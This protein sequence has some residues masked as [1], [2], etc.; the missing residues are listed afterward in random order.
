[1]AFLYEAGKTMK[2][3]FGFIVISVIVMSLICFYLMGKD[4]RKAVKNQWRVSEKTIWLTAILGG[5]LGG[6]AGM[7]VF[8]HKTKHRL[9]AIGLP[10]LA[11]L[12]AGLIG[13]GSVQFYLS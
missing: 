3:A 5:A 7:H 6:W 2:I 8:H 4:K 9:F 13:Y 11:V 1:M 12:Q 10:V